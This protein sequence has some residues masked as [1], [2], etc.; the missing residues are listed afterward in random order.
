[1]SVPGTCRKCGDTYS[2]RESHCCLCHRTFGGE[3]SGD[4]HRKGP[5]EPKGS[6][7]CV[8]DLETIGLVVVRTNR[9][10]TEVWGRRGPRSSPP[11]ANQALSPAPEG[12]TTREGGRSPETRSAET[13]DAA[14]NDETGPAY[15]LDRDHHTGPASHEG[16]D[17]VT[18]LEAITGR[19]R[20][21]GTR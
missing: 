19:R 9:F 16:H 21:H 7:Y 8:A 13:H 17:T 20:N 18:E 12:D 6:R 1:M 5:Y 3:T 10:G 15:R 11:L 2:G 14:T 4:L